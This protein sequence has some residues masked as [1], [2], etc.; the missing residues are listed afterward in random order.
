MTRAAAQ[1]REREREYT[2]QCL[3]LRETMMLI[4]GGG[5]GSGRRYIYVR[6]EFVGTA[7]KMRLC[8]LLRASAAR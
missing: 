6:D 5:G 4:V 1:E 3:S 2:S 8:C 7:G